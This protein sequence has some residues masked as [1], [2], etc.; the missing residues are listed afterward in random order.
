ME[1]LLYRLRQY[2]IKPNGEIILKVEEVTKE[3]KEEVK[4]KLEKVKASAANGPTEARSPPA[5]AA[6]A[7]GSARE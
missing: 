3:P 1:L 4:T 2:G 6:A 5:D 7:N